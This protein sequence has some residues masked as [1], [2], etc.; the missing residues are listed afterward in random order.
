ME[1]AFREEDNTLR[2]GNGVVRSIGLVR[3]LPLHKM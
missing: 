2:G 1:D 3:A